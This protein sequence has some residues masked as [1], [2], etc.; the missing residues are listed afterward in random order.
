M[1]LHDYESAR[2][3]YERAIQIDPQFAAAYNG[4][5]MALANLGR[6]TEARAAIQRAIEL[7]PD[8]PA[9]VRNLAQVDAAIASRS[10]GRG[11]AT[12]PA[13]D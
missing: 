6:L 11:T 2:A 13:G 3:A 1:L 7:Q 5:G 9:A 10:S 12:A 4:L 8:Y